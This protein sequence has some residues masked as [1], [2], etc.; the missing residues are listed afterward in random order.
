MIMK[1]IVVT[2]D[3]YQKLIKIFGVSRQIVSMALNFKTN[4]DKARR[5]RMAAMKN[6]G[7]LV[8]APMVMSI[9]NPSFD[10][11][12][13]TMT[14]EFANKVLLMANAKTG[15]VII[16]VAGERQ[17]EKKIVTI[18]ELYQLQRIAF[19]LSETVGR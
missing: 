19:D 4:S 12:E 18:E 2:T 1:R 6:G 8:G 15:E 17:M 10:T 5:I 13:R 11:V 9:P 16:T 3:V 14:F 7:S